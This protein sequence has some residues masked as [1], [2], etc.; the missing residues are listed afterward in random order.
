MPLRTFGTRAPNAS[1]SVCC[2]QCCNSCVGG[3]LNLLVLAATSTTLL[4]PFSAAASSPWPK[5]HR[6]LHIPTLAPGAPCPV[7]P[8]TLTKFGNA[9]G[10]GPVWPVLA[11]PQLSF[12]YPVQ[13]HQIYYPSDWSG[14]K[15]LWV[16]RR[17]WG[18]VLIRGAQVDG[19]NELRFGLNHVPGREMRLSSVGGHSPGGWQNRPSTTRLRAPGCYA[20]QV[21]GTTFSRVIVFRAVLS[22]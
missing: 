20:W 10:R 7:T 3:R 15:V 6:P 17:Y 11:F 22:S 19:P 14:N 1:P 13:P 8:V 2:A 4:L 21:D 18:P 16:A 12:S 9:Q 5:L